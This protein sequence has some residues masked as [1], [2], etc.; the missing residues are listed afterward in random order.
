M[1]IQLLYFPGC[2]NVDAARAALREALLG[3]G[4]QTEDAEVEEIDVSSPAAPSWAR[5][6]GSPTIL[7]DDVDVA[8]GL[9]GGATSCRLYAGGAPSVAQ[10]ERHLGRGR[11]RGQQGS[12]RLPLIGGIAAALAASAC[13]LVPAV[14][15]VVGVS[16]AG[17]ASTFTPLRPYFLVATAIALGTA[18]WFSYRKDRTCAADACGCATPRSRR[19]SRIALW[20]GA[21]LIVGVAGYPLAFDSRAS[22]RGIASARRG[23]GEVTLQITGMDCPACVPALAR[24]LADVGGVVTA[25]VD[26]DLGQAVVS[27]DGA[28]DPR[29]ELLRA[30]EQLGYRGEVIE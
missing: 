7:V 5:A 15:A 2:P 3:D 12:V 27:Y 17:L 26:Y 6:W 14:L 18:F 9:A 11:G 30:V 29:G 20:F 16:G 21:L 19:W 8:G 25:D 10:I 13:C 24:G 22:A 23:A 28:R 1:K 4:T